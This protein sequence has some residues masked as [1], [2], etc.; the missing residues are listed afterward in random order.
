MHWNSQ[1]ECEWWWCTGGSVLSGETGSEAG[2]GATQTHYVTSY[3]T[4]E[5]R[6]LHRLV[7]DVGSTWSPSS[8]SPHGDSDGFGDLV[9]E[10]HN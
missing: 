8:P 3:S 2:F 1:R 9:R 10:A 4:A 7:I 6:T 5:L